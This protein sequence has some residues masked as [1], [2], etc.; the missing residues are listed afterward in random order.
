M[1]PESKGVAVSKPFNVCV[2]GAGSSYTPEL[3]EGFI[4][5]RDELDLH[6]IRFVD[7]DPRRLDILANMAQRM[8]RHVGMDVPVQ[9]FED[10]RRSLDGADIVVSQLRVG[11]QA[12][13]Q[14]DEK[15]PLQWGVIGQE[16]TAPGG[17][18]QGLRTIAVA[19]DIAKDLREL[20][21]NAWLIN[22]TNPAGMVTEALLRHGHPKTIGVCNTPIGLEMGLAKRL[23]V[24]RREL[25]LDYVGLNYLGWVRGASV[26]GDDVWPDLLRT[27]VAE[28]RERGDV[29]GFDPSLIELLGMLPSSYLR[30]YYHH[31]SMVEHA[32]S[33][34]HTRGEEVQ[35]IESELLK[36]YEDEHLCTKPKLL[37]RRGGAY[38]STLAV[39]IIAALVNDKRE[40]FIVN[41]HN[42]G[43]I[44]NMP[45]DVVSSMHHRCERRASTAYQGAPPEIGGL[46]QAVKAYELLAVE[47]GAREDRR[48]ATPAM[49][50]HPLVPDYDAAAEMLDVLLEANGAYL[51]QFG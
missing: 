43:A 17:F 33:A 44:P 34:E 10:R 19:L 30:Y 21:P 49:L 25:T 36:M 50:A 35:A 45:G 41:T 6:S 32:R 27:I 47:A 48:A 37:E 29:A 42:H 22:F 2:I 4:D 5:R 20:A 13:R 8:F 39:A 23:G 46:V 9:R 26:G 3:I 1:Q 40:L 7:I 11:G 28:G 15:I 18:I 24:E 38:Y 16:T 31:R 51:P 14:Q 12:A